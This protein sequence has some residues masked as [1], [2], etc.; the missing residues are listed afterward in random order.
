MQKIS[1]PCI[2]TAL[3]YSLL[4]CVITPTIN[5][6]QSLTIASGNFAPYFTEEGVEGKGYFDFVILRVLTNQGYEKLNLIPL[7]NDA[8]KRYFTN[9][10]A[11]IAINYTARPP[12]K[13]YPSKYRVRFLNRVIMHSDQWSKSIQKINDLNNL[14]IGSFIGASNIFGDEYRELTKSRSVKYIEVGNQ[15]ALNK[16]LHQ[17]K[18]DVRVGDY[19]VFYWHTTHLA[20]LDANEYI[21]LDFLDYQGS[22]ILF[23]N[24][25]I[26]DKFDQGLKRLLDSNSIKELTK[27]W[28]EYYKLPVTAEQPFFSIQPELKSQ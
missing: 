12:I 21:Y 26:R 6:K 17:N 1:N 19:L 24:K 18:I 20:G 9:K 22:F 10:V 28:L 14:T 4:L 11:D 15:Q 16:Q 3:L 5:A 13:S 27:D 25:E 23:H 2:K 8:I 7:N